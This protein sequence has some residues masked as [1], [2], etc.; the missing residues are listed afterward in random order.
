LTDRFHCPRLGSEIWGG[1][2]G[3]CEEDRQVAAASE[4]TRLKRKS[5]TDSRSEQSMRVTQFLVSHDFQESQTVTVNAL[6]D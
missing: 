2:P 6:P 4:A 3:T 5:C 1:I